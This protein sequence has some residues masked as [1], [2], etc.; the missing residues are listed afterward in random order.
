M[1]F[2]GALPLFFLELSM[3]QFFKCGPITLWSKINPA[4][5]G[6]GYC[7]VLISWYVSFYYN[8]IIG[9]TFYYLF[10]TLTAGSS[11]SAFPFHLKLSTN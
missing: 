6:I 10:A 1:L 11:P 3:G 9:W 8:V 5:K 4:L 7:A 2:F